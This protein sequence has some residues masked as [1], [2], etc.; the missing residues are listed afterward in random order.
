MLEVLGEVLIPIVV[1]IIVALVGAALAWLLVT[2]A[3]SGKFKNLETAI[4]VLKSNSYTVS[5]ALQQEWVE[6][7]KAD[8]KDG[9]LTEAEIAK[10][11]AEAMQRVMDITA[12][13][14]VSLLLAAGT[15]VKLL[16]QNAVQEWV[17]DNH[18]TGK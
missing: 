6:K 15:D 16:V 13:A 7:W 9:K 8:T 18:K 2:L 5:A 3:K 14:F 11:K 17:D 1:G 12:P 10:L 4:G